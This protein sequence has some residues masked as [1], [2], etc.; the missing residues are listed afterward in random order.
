VKTAHEYFNAD[1]FFQVHDV[2]VEAQ[3]AS[4]AINVITVA[5]WVFALVTVIAGAVALAIVLSRDVAQSTADAETWRSL[6][7]TRLERAATTIPRAVL[8]ALA[9]GVLALAGAAACSPLLPVGIARRADPHPGFHLDW[10]ALGL[11]VLAIGAFVVAVSGVAAWRAARVSTAVATL[12]SSRVVQL[13][14]SAALPPT[15]AGGLRLAFQPGRGRTAVPVR[16]AFAG[17]ALGVL[18]IAALA[19]F[20]GS[21]DHLVSSPREYGWPFDFTVSQPAFA[22]GK[23]CPIRGAGIE[24]ERGVGDVALLCYITANFDSRAT[25]TWALA[26]IRGEMTPEIINGRA[27]TAP[28]EVALGSTTIKELH[29]QVGGSVRAQGAQGEQTY[30]VVGVAVFP[31]VQGQ[32]IQSLA[33]GAFVTRPGLD[34]LMNT[35]NTNAFVV[36]RFAPGA[37]RKAVTARLNRLDTVTPRESERLFGVDVGVVAASPPP[38]VDRLRHVDWF[39]PILTAL[40]GAL[41]LIA[42][43]HAMFTSVRRRR[44]DLAMLKAL[45]FERSQ[46]RAT[47]AWQATTIAVVGVAVGMPLGVIVGRLAWGR[48]ADGL[49]I[50]D[51][52][53][54]PL[55]ALVLVAVAVVVA[56]NLV[57]FFPARSASRTRPAVA[58]ATE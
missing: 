7:M 50:A 46:V 10:T 51:V 28:D 37:D 38:E 23:P 45:G 52:V 5:L 56:V 49:G 19:V 11:G 20:S 3:G 17:V 32:D 35:T 16:S 27:P 4:D 21:L 39:A 29:T 53:A 25:T 1:A 13:S 44:R 15:V 26:N 54:V 31:R 8:V 14:T 47:V 22:D 36:G 42:V 18:G 58:L 9:G 30:R 6:G 12:R 34:A 48:V 55:G 24:Q 40:L 43:A 41:A 2:R 33:D 57:A